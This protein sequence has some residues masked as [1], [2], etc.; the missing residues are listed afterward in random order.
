MTDTAR[1]PTQA[2]R[3]ERGFT[4][5]ELLVVAGI[6][7]LLMAL[8]ATIVYQ[9]MNIPRWGNARMNVDSDLR[10]AGLWLVRDGN[11]SQVF[12][13]TVPCNTFT[14]GTGSERGVEYT[15]TYMGTTLMRTDG[16]ESN[17]VAR[18]LTDRVVSLRADAI[19]LAP[20]HEAALRTALDEL[21]EARALA[22]AHVG[23]ELIAVPLRAALNA[24]A[25]L[26][27]R[28]SPDDV[29]GLVFARFCVGK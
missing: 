28:L 6:V 7:G 4:L 18:R 23:A 5:V 15:Y 19:A 29:L 9:I 13:G 20:R 14:F 10:N 25:G 11:Q 26:G 21:H 24:A 22:R 16:T 27:G 1:H 3:S 2:S 12:T 8:L 17:A